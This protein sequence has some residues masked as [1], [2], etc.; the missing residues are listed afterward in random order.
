MKHPRV[1]H[2]IWLE[3]WHA[4]HNEALISDFWVSFHVDVRF[5]VSL[6][7]D[8]GGDVVQVADSEHPTAD[9]GCGGDGKFSLCCLCRA[10][11]RQHRLRRRGAP[12]A[13][14]TST[15]KH[16]LFGVY[17]SLPIKEVL[18]FSERHLLP[19]HPLPTCSPVPFTAL[20]MVIMGMSMRG[21]G[22]NMMPVPPT[23]H[24]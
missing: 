18:Q 1:D 2:Q 19:M 17:F 16:Y 5:Y 15:C 7:K 23:N 22:H 11:L 12:P 10:A 6:I 3:V 14:Q 20:P 13:V 9:K 24:V 8:E 4:C 21:A